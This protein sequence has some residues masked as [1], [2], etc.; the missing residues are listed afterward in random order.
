MTR[1]RVRYNLTPMQMFEWTES[2]QNINK[3]WQRHCQ[4][5]R[6][7]EIL[8]PWFR[9]QTEVP[10]RSVTVLFVSNNLCL[11]CCCFLSRKS[12]STDFNIS[13]Q[14]G[15]YALGEAHMGSILFLKRS[16]TLLLK[17][18]QCSSDWRWP[19]FVL[20]RKI[21]E[22]FLFPHFYLPGDWWCDALG[23]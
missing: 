23:E 2:V 22:R 18:F 9:I 16:L 19:F 14:D 8:T 10:L 15:I 6:L 17:Q 1:L 4:F 3:Y 13:V 12:L 11:F 20:S 5:L 21:T 7:M